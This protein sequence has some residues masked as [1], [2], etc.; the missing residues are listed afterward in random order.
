MANLQQSP[1]VA[2]YELEIKWSDNGGLATS[3]AT[4]FSDTLDNE[5]AHPTPEDVARAL[6]DWYA[7]QAGYV[8]SKLYYVG[9]SMDLIA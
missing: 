1:S 7:A 8:S 2:H 4:V 5:V 9:T 6:R 3:R